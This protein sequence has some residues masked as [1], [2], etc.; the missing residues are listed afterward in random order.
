MSTMRVCALL[1]CLV[2]PISLVA[3]QATTEDPG[4]AAFDKGVEAYNNRD[5]PGA[6]THFAEALKSFPGNAT[7]LTWLGTTCYEL[8]Q[9]DEAIDNLSKATQAD[10]K[11]AVAFNNLG[12]ACLEKGTEILKGGNDKDGRPLLEKAVGA[13]Q[14]AIGLDEKYF[15][16]RYNLAITYTRMKEWE[17]A[18]KAFTDATKVKPD[19]PDVWK[20]FGR[21]LKEAGEYDKALDRYQKAADLDKKCVECAVQLGWLNSKQGH[22]PEAEQAYKGAV[23]LEADNFDAQL[24]LGIALYSQKKH[25][26]ARAPLT[27]AG[28]LH[29]DS[30]EAR[31]DLGLTEDSLNNLPA[32]EIAYRAAL[33]LKASDVPCLNNLGVVIYKQDKPCD[34]VTQFRAAVAGDASYVMAQINLALALEACGKDDQAALDQ[35]KATVKAFPRQAGA[36]CGLANALYRRKD[37]DGA[38]AEYLRCLELEDRNVEAHDNVGLIFLDKGQ[39]AEAIAHFRQALQVDPKNLAALNNLGVTYEKM[40]KPDEAKKYYEQALQIDPNCQRAKENLDRLKGGH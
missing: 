39:S 37:L 36:H 32:A 11:Y 2:L 27:R 6:K 8:K 3:A 14:T 30:F 5:F 15:Y 21:A 40:G 28:E 20:S 25:P 23:A 34:A 12:N 31:Y 19:D 1:F 9:W 38:L 26:D 4:R 22:W 18:W 17:K 24:G 7:V 13:Y 16:P 33:A 35:W 29:A 10:P